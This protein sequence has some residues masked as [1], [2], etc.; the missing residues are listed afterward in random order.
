MSQENTFNKIII[1]NLKKYVILL[2]VQ[3]LLGI[4]LKNERRPKKD[5]L[6]FCS[7]SRSR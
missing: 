2:P 3:Q 6:E 1:S 5:L 7:I 4:Y